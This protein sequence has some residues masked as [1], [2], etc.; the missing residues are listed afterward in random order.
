[1]CELS[2]EL[3]SNVDILIVNR[4][5]TAQLSGM[6][7]VEME[8]IEQACAVLFAR[9]IKTIVVTLGAKGAYLIDAT[10]RTYLPSFPVESIDT[11]GAG[12]SFVGASR[13]TAEE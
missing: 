5:E 2:D 9:G 8:D 12:D 7:V 4:T 10:H 6:P 3:I 1:M 11:V 13:W